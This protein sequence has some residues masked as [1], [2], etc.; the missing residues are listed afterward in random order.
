MRN[1]SEL[2]SLSS[3]KYPTNR[4]LSIGWKPQSSDARGCLMELQAWVITPHRIPLRCLLDRYAM[5]RLNI[6]LRRFTSHPRTPSLN[7]FMI[8]G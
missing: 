8:T 5:A 3:W 7:R 4:E 2:V 6:V 1:L